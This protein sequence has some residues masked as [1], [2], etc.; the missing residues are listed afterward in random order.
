MTCSRRVAW[1]REV[2]FV[3]PEALQ[4]LIDA[5]EQLA[6]EFKGEEHAA[7]DDRRLVESVVCLA[8]QPVRE[9]QYLLVGV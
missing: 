9:P 8:N 5:G 6:V 2:P 3:T 4:E 1:R 7:L